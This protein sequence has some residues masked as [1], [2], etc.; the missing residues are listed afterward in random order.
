M[1]GKIYEAKNKQEG[2]NKDMIGKTGSFINEKNNFDGNY[3]KTKKVG[4]QKSNKFKSKSADV[5]DPQTT[6]KTSPR[7]DLLLSINSQGATNEEIDIC[8]T[9]RLIKGCCEFIL[10]FNIFLKKTLKLANYSSLRVSISQ[11]FADSESSVKK[12]NE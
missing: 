4:K 9:V 7:I 3:G 10:T 5:V 2:D 1:D 8:Q 11:N 12:R 6:T